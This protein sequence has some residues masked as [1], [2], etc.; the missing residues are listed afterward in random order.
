MIW[1]ERR[2]V[3]TR[4]YLQLLA[5]PVAL[6]AATA[7]YA[8]NAAGP[9]AS[10]LAPPLVVTPVDESRLVRLTGNTRPEANARNDRGR[11]PDSQVFEHLQ[12]LLGR[13]P[14]RER[15]LQDLIG[16]LQARGSPDYH[17]W[18]TA[19]MLAQRF[20]P[21]QSDVDSVSHWLRGHGFTVNTV[22][23]AA[24]AIDFTGTAGQIRETF[25][26]EVHAIDVGGT[27][28][29]ANMSDPQ[30]PAAL[31]PVVRGVVSLNDFMPRPLL[32]PRAQYSTSGGQR[33]VAPADLAAIY[34]L[35]PVF[36]AGNT[37]QNQTVVVLEDTD[38]YSSSDWSAF[39]S[40]FNLTAYSGASF[41]QVHPAPQKG[42]S[43]CTD[44]GVVGGGRDGEATLDAEWASAA[45]PSAAIEVAVCADTSTTF[46]GLIALQNLLNS[47]SPPA[48]ISIS[49]GECEAADGA[50]ANA[51]FDSTY[52]TAAA[53]GVSIFVGA[54][55]SGAAGCDE[56]LTD[57]AH[58]IG[59]NALAST[60]YNVAV[61]GTDF[62]D[63]Y[64]GSGTSY[65]TSTNTANFGS[66]L[67]Y[68]PEI[69][70]NDSCAG[71]LLANFVGFGPSYGSGG[72]CNSSVAT[73]YLIT[74]AGSGGPS[75]CA[76]GTAAQSSVVGGSCAGYAKP[77][78][79]SGPGVPADGVRDLP[80]VSMFAGNG[81]WGHYYVYCWSDTAA[82]G[83]ACTG[84][85]SGWSG[86]GGTSFAAPIL[87]GIQALV[88]A[89]TNSRQGNPNYVYYALA[90][91]QHR[92]GLNCNA[93]AGNAA[94]AQC[95]FYD[96]TLGDIDVDCQGSIDCYLP[97]GSY[98]VLSTSDGSDATAYTAATGWDFASGNGSVNAKNLIGTWNS[99]DVSIAGSGAINA[100]GQS[101]YTLDLTNGGPQIASAVTVTATLPA[102]AALVTGP[103]SATC[104]QS[105]QALTCTAGT[106]AVQ[107]TAMLL[108]VIQPGSAVGDNVNFNV[109]ESNAGINGVNNV[110]AATLGVPTSGQV[111]DVP[112]APWSGFALAAALLGLVNLR[113]RAT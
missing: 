61:G 43:N 104:S 87:A 38:V 5:L 9:A 37:G 48:I 52:A 19:A 49:Y 89:N 14:D 102:G 45:A 54:G 39:R 26:C 40:T 17:R 72:F 56:N 35:A 110:Y 91:S 51:A 106:L 95:V 113:A 41:S 47:G 55:D 25:R 15:A 78:W 92:A 32:R 18:W 12:L 2:G 75:R 33:L 30:I 100:A 79:Q 21:A 53:E 63:T 105:G 29:I 67:S 4:Q 109:S 6:C 77:S 22:Y 99:A 86:A 65:W 20:G 90:G 10:V 97:S 98:G 66:A 13:P 44:P 58:G 108:V 73:P 36:A 74:V 46:G 84:P 1:L 62:G 8:Q 94:S 76:T 112:L 28:H 34:S 80:D 42:P 7:L 81:L 83:K 85:P 71:A 64:A 16:R 24:P 57:A 50:T 69:P 59:V 70:W 101:A 96:L 88:N 82:G 111:T 103:S 23:G 11:V 93:T 3:L 60:P 27:R 31:A 68:V 107:G